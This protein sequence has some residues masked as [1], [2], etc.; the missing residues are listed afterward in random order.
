M[1]PRSDHKNIFP[2]FP[3]IILYTRINSKTVA[4]PLTTPQMHFAPGKPP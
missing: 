4:P 2:K 3:V 1:I